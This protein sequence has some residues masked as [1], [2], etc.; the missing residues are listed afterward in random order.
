MISI[1]D[2]KLVYALAVIFTSIIAIYAY[3]RIKR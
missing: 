1:G 2:V 3:W